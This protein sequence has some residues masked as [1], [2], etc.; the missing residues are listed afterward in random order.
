MSPPIATYI[1]IVPFVIFLILLSLNF[2]GILDV[3][4]STKETTTTPVETT[5][6]P[7]TTT[8][9][10]ITTPE[11]EPPVTT[12]TPAPTPAPVTTTPPLAPCYQGD[13]T[14]TWGHAVKDA[15]WACNSWKSNCGNKGGCVASG[16]G[17]VTDNKSTWACNL[18]SNCSA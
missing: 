17:V 15:T 6:Q 11:P 3:F 13:V 8:P 18:T 2:A 5:T 12:T 4:W 16:T 9:V 10:P 1:L 14:I 7:P